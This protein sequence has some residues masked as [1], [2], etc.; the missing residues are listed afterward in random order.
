[1][2]EEEKKKT[3]TDKAQASIEKQNLISM[4]LCL[5]CREYIKHD[6]RDMNVKG[7]CPTCQSNR[8]DNMTIED[9]KQLCNEELEN[10][11]INDIS[12]C[13]DTHDHYLLGKVDLANEILNLI[14][15]QAD[16]QKG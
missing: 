12:L 7:Y 11:E 14:K 1:M 16:I 8:K 2:T 15:Q 4:G 5:K 10:T 3:E 9:I 13:E 6:E